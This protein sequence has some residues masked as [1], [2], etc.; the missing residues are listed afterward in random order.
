VHVH[1]TLL[2]YGEPAPKTAHS[3]VDLV[4]LG[5]AGADPR[6][7]AA[8]GAAAKVCV[9][10]SAQV[11][12]HGV[13]RLITKIQLLYVHSDCAQTLRFRLSALGGGGGSSDVPSLPHNLGVIVVPPHHAGAVAAG[14][15]GARIIYEPAFVH[16]DKLPVMHYVGLEERI[17][18]ETRTWV[19][20][21]TAAAATAYRTFSRTDPLLVF[22]QRHGHLF[23]EL[24][25]DD[26][27]L[28]SVGDEC[29]YLVKEALVERAQRFF[30]T[31]VL[32]LINYLPD[33]CQH[34]T[35]ALEGGGDDSVAATVA[36]Q[37]QVDYVSVFPSGAWAWPCKELNVTPFI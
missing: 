28:R 5:P 17:M 1:H 35:L 6:H 23:D 36:L 7:A 24:S 16:L 15:H 30:R 32:P 29:V 26:R 27:Q 11:G 37:F 8:A 19:G 14:A 10:P 12:T 13:R 25:L 20:T 22:L 18:S 33:D 2:Q 4:I 9:F 34:L 3:V 21:P 31:Q